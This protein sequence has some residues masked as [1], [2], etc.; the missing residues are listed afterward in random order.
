MVFKTKKCLPFIPYRRNVRTPAEIIGI[1]MGEHCRESVMRGMGGRR[2]KEEWEDI[3]LFD[4]LTK[5]GNNLLD[6]L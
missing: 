4:L 3:Q 1:C 2:P 6:F 5:Q